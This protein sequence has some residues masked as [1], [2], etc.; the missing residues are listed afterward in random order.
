MKFFKFWE[1]RPL[2]D[3]SHVERVVRLHQNIQ[4]VPYVPTFEHML[5]I[6]SEKNFSVYRI[7]RV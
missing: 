7:V 1:P 3:G 4:I 2:E 6:F 5:V